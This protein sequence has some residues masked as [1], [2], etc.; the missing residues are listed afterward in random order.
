MTTWSLAGELCAMA[1]IPGI[2]ESSAIQLLGLGTTAADDKSLKSIPVREWYRA[3]AETYGYV[4]DVVDGG[5]ST[6]GRYY[7]KACVS[8]QAER[9][10]EVVETWLVRRLRL[11]ASGISVPRLYATRAATILEEYIEHDWVRCLSAVHVNGDTRSCD[12]LLASVALTLG[13]L[14]ELRFPA[15]G[16]VTDFRSHGADTVLVD[17]GADLG[18]EGVASPTTS[19]D[20]EQMLDVAD[21]LGVRLSRQQLVRIAE[22]FERG[23]RKARAGA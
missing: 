8:Y 19:A 21:D 7:L 12:E 2:D 10:G 6:I 4:F 15:L 5:S 1:R 22:S 13:I 18:D 20:L 23:V 17:F 11:E 3:G 14:N 16:G 9:P